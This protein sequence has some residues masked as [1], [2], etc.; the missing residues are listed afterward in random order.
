MQLNV[1]RKTVTLPPFQDLSSSE[2][3]EPYL[4]IKLLVYRPWVGKQDGLRC[5]WVVNMELV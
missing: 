4:P 2:A 5:I 3:F 1:A